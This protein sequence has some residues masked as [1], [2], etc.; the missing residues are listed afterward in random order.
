M[1]PDGDRAAKP[2]AA[3]LASPALYI[4]RETSWL[5]FNA[6]V[7]DEA[8]DA[9]LAAARA[10]EVPGDLLVEPGRVLHDPRL[11]AARAARG[12]RAGRGQPR[13]PRAR[14]S[15]SP[16]SARSSAGSCETAADAAGRRSA[17]GAG[18]RTGSGSATGSA[19]D[20]ETK[21]LARK[22]FRRSV[23]P[24]VTPL[25]VD[26][27]PPVPV[28]LEP[29][30]VAGG[31]GARSGDQG[32]EVRAHQGPGDPAALRPASRAST[33]AARPP[34]PATVARDFLPLE[35]LIAANLDELF[36]GMEIL[37]D[38]PVSRHARHGLRHPRG[39]GARPAVDRRPRDPAPAL[40]RLRAAGGRRRDPGA[41]PHAC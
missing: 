6:R 4:N 2:S 36:P 21:Q 30:A 39:R 25:A 34:R 18:R 33:P 1:A 14:A 8:L 10:A 5:A 23:F 3:D 7:L 20:A 26:P 32:T 37:G 17:P 27:G 19:L 22:Y 13:R 24:V 41:H 16:A 31:R 35:Q 38:L 12:G 9:A 28:P 40:R 11:G 29:L 15:S